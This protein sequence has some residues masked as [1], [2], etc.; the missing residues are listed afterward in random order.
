[1]EARALM[2]AN[3]L[4]DIYSGSWGPKDDGMMLDGPGVMAQMAFE[5]GALR[6]IK[7]CLIHKTL[8]FKLKL[9]ICLTA[10]SITVN[11]YN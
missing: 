5:V 9:I 7:I 10:H 8:K 3:M 11:T 2:N 1:M 6:V 4:V